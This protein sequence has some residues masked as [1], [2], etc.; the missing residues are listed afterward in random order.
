MILSA[1]NPVIVDFD[2]FS[3]S[4]AQNH[5]LGTSFNNG[6][7]R[8]Y[9]YAMAGAADLAAGK[10]GT[11]P[12]QK[13]NHHNCTAIASAAGTKNPT[14]TLGATAA[15]DSE[16]D[17]GYVTVNV[18]PDVGRVYKVSHMG[19]IGS[20][21]TATPTLAEPIVTA[22]TTATRVNL[23]HNAWRKTIEGTVSTIRPAGVPMTAVTTLNYYWAQSRGV[24]AVLCDTTTTLGAVQKCSGSVAGAVTDQ[25]DNLGAS[26]ELTVGVAS[27][28][29][30]A[31]TEYRPIVLTID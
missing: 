11:A 14:F 15:V 10:V 31:D 8:A 17:E 27:I 3:T 24:A 9:R 28:M 20:G 23:V 30:G 1:A 21:G 25:T 12:T 29:A 18:T 16:Y 7:G 13:T 4:T 2:P 5:A 6:E 22:W 19:A 26:S